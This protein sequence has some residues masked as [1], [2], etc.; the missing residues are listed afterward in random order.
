MKKSY[1]LFAVFVAACGLQP[2]AAQ[3]S[4]DAAEAR[5]LYQQANA[6]PTMAATLA[7]MTQQ[8]TGFF[9][10]DTFQPGALRTFDGRYRPVPGLRYHASLH[11]LEAQ[12]SIDTEVTHLWPVGSLRG[13]DLGDAG[14]QGA[15]GLHRF[16]PRLVKEGSAGT[17]RDFVEV[18]T[19]VDAGPLLLAWLYT[20]NGEAHSL[21][22]RAFDGVLVAGS[23]TNGAEPLRPLEASQT[24]VLRLFGSRADDV[25]AFATTQKLDYTRP[26]DIAKMMDHYNRIA[27]V[28]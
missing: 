15:G 6:A 9:G 11:V 2:A 23:G 25:R 7:A 12:D 5:T 21:Q 13:F 26:A 27:V 3:T 17:R 20:S 28:K 18:L 24:T 22:R 4:R 8:P 19:A 1:Y 14:A 16:R 10:D